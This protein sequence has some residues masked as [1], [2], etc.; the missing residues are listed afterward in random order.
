MFS[1]CNILNN[2]GFARYMKTTINKR[3]SFLF[4]FFFFFFFLKTQ[5]KKKKGKKKIKKAGGFG[6]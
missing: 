5:Q 4:F 6:F 3:I 2:I 1:V